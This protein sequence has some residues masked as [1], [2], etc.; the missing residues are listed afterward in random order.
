MHILKLFPLSLLPF[1]P[2]STENSALIDK[3]AKLE[4]YLLTEVKCERFATKHAAEKEIV[5][6]FTV[7][8]IKD[9]LEKENAFFKRNE[10]MQL[11]PMY[12]KGTYSFVVHMGEYSFEVPV[13]SGSGLSE[14]TR[15]SSLF[16]SNSS[17]SLMCYAEAEPGQGAGGV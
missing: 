2:M 5:F 8:D 16:K 9:A 13:P 14:R 6:E 11:S 4:E 15:I 10:T 1:S 3:Q 17:F 7:S 12:I